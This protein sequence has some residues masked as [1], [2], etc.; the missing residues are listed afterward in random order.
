MEV[1]GDEVRELEAENFLV[2][3]DASPSVVET[4]QLEFGDDVDVVRA[5]MTALIVSVIYEVCK[6][7]IQWWSRFSLC[8]LCGLCD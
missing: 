2:D 4:V 5:K 7:E 1:E 8:D 3:D 6:Q